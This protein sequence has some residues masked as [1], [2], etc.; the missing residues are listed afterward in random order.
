MTVSEQHA[1]M[2]ARIPTELLLD[3]FELA[4]DIPGF[5][6]D[7]HSDP[8]ERPG[9]RTPFLDNSD[10][11]DAIRS[12]VSIK[13]ALVRV[14]RRWHAVATPLLYRALFVGHTSTLSLLAKTLSESAVLDGAAAL[15]THTRRL[16]LAWSNESRD[17]AVLMA[18]SHDVAEPLREIISCL[19]GLK[20]ASVSVRG[21][22]TLVPVDI[23]HALG[24]TCGPSLRRLDWPD[25]GLSPVFAGIGSLLRHTPN[26]RVNLGTNIS[27]SD[28]Y[29]SGL[30]NLSFGEFLF[31]NRDGIYPLPLFPHMRQAIFHAYPPWD[32]ATT[33]HVHRLLKSAPNLTTVH[34]EA[35]ECGLEQAFSV[36]H[37]SGI[38]R[39]VLCA[40]KWSDLLIDSPPVPPS[41]THL[42]LA[43][44]SPGMSE[45]VCAEVFQ[46]L[47]KVAD[48]SQSLRSVRILN[49][50][51]NAALLEHAAP[52]KE[53][54][55]LMEKRGI[56]VEDSWG[57]TIKSV[58]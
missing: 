34:L 5:L 54:V 3:I 38:P 30:P 50:R 31:R 26:L 17:D 8:F 16:D 6:N 55:I 41:L 37:G 51:C 39:I 2:A 29:V 32:D 11:V 48:G 28:D 14:C 57:Q 25:K 4:T 13:R 42:G 19:P 56:R 27:L 40:H 36:L 35:S 9:V 10:E 23:L 15:G 45:R 58:A 24:S 44:R 53:D 22:W 49:P 1:F 20:I 33:V 18:M 12:A 7:D 47:S 43:V 46:W 21:S 52:F